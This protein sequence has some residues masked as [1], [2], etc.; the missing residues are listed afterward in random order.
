M[1]NVD[2]NIELL[3]LLYR[4]N[5]TYAL[6][7]MLRVDILTINNEMPSEADAVKAMRSSKFANDEEPSSIFFVKIIKEP[8]PNIVK[9]A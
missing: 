7:N 8:A 9:K 5:D 6:Y 4:M 3:E 2:Y 1:E